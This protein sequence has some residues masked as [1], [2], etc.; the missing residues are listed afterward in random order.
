M[1]AKT[2]IMY[3]YVWSQLPTN[4]RRNLIHRAVNTTAINQLYELLWF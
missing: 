2:A 3:R 1:T 4:V